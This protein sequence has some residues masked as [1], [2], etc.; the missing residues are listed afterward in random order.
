[1]NRRS[2]L[3][4]AL[5]ASA[6]S[7]AA[8]AAA[9]AAGEVNIYSYRQEVLI[10]PLLDAFSKDSGIKV[11]LVTVRDGML[12]RLRA[13]GSASP[14]DVVLT[15]DAGNLIAMEKAGLLAPSKSA[16]LEANIPA[17]YRHPEG[18]WYGLS[19]RAR[20]IMFNPA[21]VKAE[22]LSTYENLADPKWKGRIC[23][24]TSGHI[25]NLSL[26]AT[27]IAHNGAEKTEAWAKG[28]TANLARKPAGGDRDQ[29]NAL[30]AGV[31]DI[32]IANTYYLAGMAVS[33]D[34][35]ERKTA[36]AVRV[37]WPNQAGRGA[38]VNISG[39]AMTAA[40]KNKAEALKLM[41]FLSGDKAQNIY[42]EGVQEYPVKPGIAMSATLRAFGEF[43]A[44]ALPLAK[45]AE[46]QAEALKI[47]DRAGWR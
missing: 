47:V 36:E 32:A 16:I 44:D 39:I 40:A 46:Y 11:T 8:T 38:H 20:P 37:F 14:A 30:V 25:Y 43:K 7:F 9:H 4:A 45:I 21:K 34:E 24:R 5:L 35:K 12:E 22:E 13:E 3:A 2:L 19:M 15:V 1:M 18:R 6:A 26:I 33:K 42:A 23:I 27:L 41:E 29:I 17:A 28:F 31:C 10:K